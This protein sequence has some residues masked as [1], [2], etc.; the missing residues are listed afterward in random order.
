MLYQPAP[1]EAVQVLRPFAEIIRLLPGAFALKGPEDRYTMGVLIP[2]RADE[3]LAGTGVVAVEVDWIITRPDG[4]YDLLTDHE[5][6]RVR[7]FAPVSQPL[8][9]TAA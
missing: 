1:D 6:R 5:F 7:G 3:A 9:A 2:E 4:S 8:L